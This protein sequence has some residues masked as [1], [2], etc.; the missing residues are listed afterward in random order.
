[1][2]KTLSETISTYSGIYQFTNVQTQKIYIGSSYNLRKRFLQHF[3][4]L[5]LSNHHSVHFQN[6]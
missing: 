1:M 6:S 2:E 4:K 5:E 3:N